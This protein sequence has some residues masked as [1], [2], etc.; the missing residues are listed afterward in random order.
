MYKFLNIEKNEQK[1]VN[2]LVLYS[3]LIGAALAYYVTSTTSLFLNSFDRSYISI[4]FIIAGVLQWLIGKLMNFIF[5]KLNFSTSLPIVL[6]FLLVSVT[7]FIVLYRFHKS[8]AI[9]FLLYT[10]IRIFSYIHAIVFWSMAGK[11]FNLQQAKRIFGVITGG[12]VVASIMSFFSVPFLLKFI[13][14]TD[15]LI[16]SGSFLVLTFA[17]LIIIVQ[18]FNSNFSSKKETK[19]FDKNLKINLFGSKYYKLLFWIAFIPIFAQFFVEYI[20]QAQAKIE[21]PSREEL[22]AFIGVFMGFS[23]IVEFSLKT[24]ASGN[25]LNKY[26]IKL[27]LLAL[28]IVL[29]ISFFL[30]SVFGIFFGTIG[31]F[32]SF[33][34]M[35]RLFT[36]AVRTAFQDSSN[37]IL[38]QPLTPNIRILIQNKIESGPK[39]YASIVAGIF[40]Y[41]INFIPN[42]S[43]AFISLL[44][45]IITIIWIWISLETYK[46]YKNQVQSYLDNFKIDTI[47]KQDNSIKKIINSFVEKNN[48]FLSNNILNLLFPVQKIDTQN[49]L[50]LS[51]IVDYSNSLNVEER[52]LAAKH[53]VYFNIYKTEKLFSKLLNDTNFDVRCQTIISAGL[54]NE[55][56][57]FDRIIDNFKTNTYRYS[58]SIAI[59]QI[60]QPIIPK[61]ISA[62]YANEYNSEFQ[63]EIIKIILQIKSSKVIEFLR[64]LINY[65]SKDVQQCAISALVKIGYQ[66]TRNEKTIIT[67]FLKNELSQLVYICASLN[68]LSSIPNNDELIEELKNVEKNKRDNIFDILSLL[69]PQKTIT[70]LKENLYE[71]NDENKGFAI[72]I[73]HNSLTEIHKELLLPFLEAKHSFDLVKKYKHTFVQENLNIFDRL[74]DLINSELATTGIF[75]KTLAIRKLGDFKNEKTIKF[76]NTLVISP[77]TIIAENAA[78]TLLS[79]SNTDFENSL[80][81]F[82]TK[83]SNLKNIYLKLTGDSSQT[84]LLTSE[85]IIYLKDIELFKKLHYSQLYYISQNCNETFVAENKSYSLTDFNKT[86]IHLLVFGTLNINNNEFE[87]GFVFSSFFSNINEN[88]NLIAMDYSLVLRIPLFVIINL[89]IQ[90]HQFCKSFYD[91]LI[92]QKEKLPLTNQNY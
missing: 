71:Q 27:G 89:F 74:I 37:Q 13:D 85:K 61:I 47:E 88:Q 25:L 76:L 31:L 20:F 22:T 2:F 87:N 12:E 58:A 86:N 9:I 6:L 91:C 8:S 68:D 46:E 75:V 42:F 51:E 55:K 65:P 59:I 70:L 78:N 50:K 5:K 77:I 35:G 63:I 72:E 23:A 48:N 62:F 32:F 41:I 7:I 60:G 38:Y 15:I 36:R 19:I 49:H 24:F 53:L 14:T 67:D 80:S 79:I 18:K 83:N 81:V 39:A 82:I 64:N 73:A 4:S 29:Y 40:L 33:V 3:F 92:K 11:L 56:E 43:L 90:N 34:A 1:I 16:I 30:A 66:T 44:L 69:Y 57:L 52:L 54:T 84:K 45:F 21:L 28:P 26:G 10:W 17:F